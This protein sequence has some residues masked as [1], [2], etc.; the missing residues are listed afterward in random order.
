MIVVMML[1]TAVTTGAYAS[2]ELKK[3]AVESLDAAKTLVKSGDYTKAVDEINYALS[4]LNELTA[5]GLLTF[6]PNAPAGF[7]LENKSAQGMGQAASVVGSAAAEAHYVGK[8]DATVKVLITL[9]GVSGQMGSLANFGSMFAAFGGEQNGMKKI[10]IQGFTGTLQYDA[11]SMNGTVSIQAGAKTS[12]QIEGNNIPS[13]ESLKTFANAIN[14][15]K[16]SS[17]F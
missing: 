2:D 4:K 3:E 15:S 7:T 9:G 8:D 12:V 6:I 11:S 14:L 13:E 16:L 5:A 17:A 10:R 1:V